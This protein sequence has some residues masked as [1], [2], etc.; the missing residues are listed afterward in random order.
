MVSETRELGGH[1]VRWQY[2]PAVLVTLTLTVFGAAS[3]SAATTSISPGDT[4]ANALA[5]Q[6]ASNPALFSQAEAAL[7]T[8]N[9]VDDAQLAAAKSDPALAR[10]LVSESASD[11][12][13]AAQLLMHSTSSQS[14][15]GSSVAQV[16]NAAGVT[17]DAQHCYGTV[18]DRETEYYLGITEGWDETTASWCTGPDDGAIVSVT[19]AFPYFTGATFC[20]DSNTGAPISYNGPDDAF[21]WDGSHATVDHALDDGEL[22]T[23]VN[24][25]C[26]PENNLEAPLRIW[27][28]GSWDDVD[29]WGF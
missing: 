8:P 12:A 26:Y 15:I 20:W 13:L 11:P 21:P 2:V 22:G 17:P 7:Y 10:Q 6:G 1:M 28:T 14:T 18:G 19:W 23:G 16:E 27:Y 29:D 9:P 25:V 4:T 3:A 5:V 24:G